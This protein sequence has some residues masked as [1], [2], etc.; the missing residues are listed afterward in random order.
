MNQ[1]PRKA[2]RPK[3][4][5]PRPVLPNPDQDA[6]VRILWRSEHPRLAS[7][8]F[9]RVELCVPGPTRSDVV[10]LAT[11]AQRL[12]RRGLLQHGWNRYGLVTLTLTPRGRRFIGLRYGDYK[13]PVATS[14]MTPVVVACTSVSPSQNQGQS[15]AQKYTLAELPPKPS[16]VVNFDSVGAARQVLVNGK[17]TWLWCTS[18]DC[19]RPTIKEEAVPTASSAPKPLEMPLAAPLPSPQPAAVPVAPATVR[20]VFFAFAAGLPEKAEEA[21]FVKFSQGVDRS[22]RVLVVG[23]TDKSGSAALNEKLAQ[24]RA[25]AIRALL[26]KQGFAEANISVQIDVS[27]ARALPQGGTDREKL[28][29]GEAQFRRVDVTFS[30]AAAPKAKAPQDATRGVDS[31]RIAATTA[32]H[33]CVTEKASFKVPAGIRPKM[34]LARFE[35]ALGPG[36]R[37]TARAI[38]LQSSGISAFDAELAR[39]VER[40]LAQEITKSVTVPTVLTVDFDLFEQAL[41]HNVAARREEPVGPKKKAEA[42]PTGSR[43]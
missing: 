13:R 25:E 30:G 4:P 26:V 5:G 24:R 38:M 21:A 39:A 28:A 2:R 18:N 41:K 3:L 17:K 42:A 34:H 22:S 1:G 37:Q 8:V 7:E 12:E 36:G 29:P 40:C 15:P 14:L 10:A 43:E 32:L 33:G 23:M 9:G 20:S 35:V 19:I 27:G 16:S 11:E 31:M 6:I